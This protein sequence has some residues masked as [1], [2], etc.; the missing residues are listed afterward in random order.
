[1]DVKHEVFKSDFNRDFCLVQNVRMGEE[2][3]NESMRLTN[4]LVIAAENYDK[5]GS[6]STVLIPTISQ[7]MD[8]QLKLSQID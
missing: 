1:M 5:E 8:E 6:L 2:G 3:F 4:Q 7:D